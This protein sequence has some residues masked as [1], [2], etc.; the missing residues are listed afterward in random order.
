MNRIVGRVCW[1][2]LAVIGVGV[3]LLGAAY[4]TLI[5]RFNPNPPSMKFPR[6]ADPA[7]AQRQDLTYFRALLAMD[8]SFSPAARAEAQQAITALESS[9]APLSRQQLHVALM[10]IMALAD[11][12]HS[13][14]SIVPSGAE[15]DVL[16][17]RVTAFSDGLYVMRA[18]R[19]DGEILGSRVEAVDNV[20]IDSVLTQLKSLRG[21]L[22]GFRLDK[23]ALYLTVQDL[24]NGLGISPDTGKSSWTV[25]LP[26]GAIVTRSLA[27]Y[28]LGDTEP[29]ADAPRWMSP[30]PLEAMGPD[31]LSLRP[32]A[33][34]GALAQSL[35][36]FDVAF[37]RE[38]I[39]KSCATYVR[40]R[41]ISDEGH[42]QIKPF[43]RSTE[44]AFHAHPPC[45]I[46]LDLRYSAGG[47]FTN[48]YRFMRHLPTLVAPGGHVYVL[49]DAMTFSA[50]ITTAGFVK[51]A[52]G[53][54]V[55][56]V[57]EPMGDRLVF[58][59]E[60]NRGCLP[61]SK[62][63][64]D[65]ATGKHDY[66]QPCSDWSVC[67]WLTWLYPVRVKTLSPDEFIPVQFSDWNLG[68]DVAF[69]RS[70]QLANQLV[71]R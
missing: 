15:V 30:E 60:G 53:D 51:E 13:Q 41:A 8:K 24:L 61:N 2:S 3:A 33:G 10:K 25:R 37:V 9:A 69:E 12:G 23:A 32:A 19:V 6:P 21:G 44:D 62:L 18:R 45:A 36:N 68:H 20:P 58:F 63:C 40:M 5:H 71:L 26:S 49:T 4:G 7:E 16:P 42:Q 55:T 47:D 17:V 31:W 28:P 52:G 34:E 67:F 1:T 59:A 50:A 70:V 35:R 29:L 46:I 54:A 43:I 14:V 57:G 22:P 27:A 39:D 11:N 56:I 65:Y 66:T 64:V 48:T 38:S